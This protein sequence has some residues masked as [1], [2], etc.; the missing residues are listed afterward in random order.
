MVYLGNGRGWVCTRSTQ[1][2]GSQLFF[3]TI[4]NELGVT[5]KLMRNVSHVRGAAPRGQHA[6]L[7][8]KAIVKLPLSRG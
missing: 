2:Q 5:S 3:N 7:H 4:G 6:S 1:K 8:Q